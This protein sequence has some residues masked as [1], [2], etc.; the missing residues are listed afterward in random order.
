[1]RIVDWPIQEGRALWRLY[2]Q[3]I[4]FIVLLLLFRLLIKQS[5]QRRVRMGTS[6]GRNQDF[7]IVRRVIFRIQVSVWIYDRLD[8]II[9]RTVQRLTPEHVCFLFAD[10]ECKLRVILQHN[11]QL[12]TRIT[13]L[14]SW[15]MEGSFKDTWLDVWP[16]HESDTCFISV[17]ECSRDG[18][19]A[20]AGVRQCMCQMCPMSSAEPPGVHV[21]M[22]LQ[23]DVC[24]D[25]GP[26]PH[27]SLLSLFVRP[28]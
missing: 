23:W 27:L 3:K 18:Q 12:T 10:I 7:K 8:V 4:K 28:H 15:H 17:I 13:V 11:A 19:A 1:M 26:Q 9:T 2:T 20:Q 22:S 24:C 25:P 21:T 6:L 16:S 14:L 5:V